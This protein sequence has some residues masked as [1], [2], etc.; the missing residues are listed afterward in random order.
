MSRY[1]QDSN[2]S[3]SNR[4]SN[5]RRSLEVTRRSHDNYPQGAATQ[6]EGV[7]Q[8]V[9]RCYY[10]R[11][12]GVRTN[13]CRCRKTRITAVNTA[14]E[15]YESAVLLI[16]EGKK[17]RSVINTGMQETRIGLGVLE[18]LQSKKTLNLG[19]KV[20]R[21]IH[22]LETLQVTTT[23]ITLP[24][25]RNYQIECYVDSRIRKNEMMIG[26]QAMIKLGYRI[27][28]AGQ[29]GRQRKQRDDSELLHQ[30][31]KQREDDEI[32]FLDEEEARRI[33]EWG[34]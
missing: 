28:I 26:F 14:H 18:F 13:D 33:N 12:R 21:S 7:V 6:K 23:T 22:G 31:L 15:R 4:R 2:N 10:C 5:I 20:L 30:G 32:S 34:N 27:T 25:N 29:E 24:G 9:R 11:R 8:K 3:Q 17:I 1:V 19:R 16:V